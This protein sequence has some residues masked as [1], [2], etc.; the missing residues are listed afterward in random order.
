MVMVVAAVSALSSVAVTVVEPPFSAIVVLVSWSVATAAS[1][2]SSSI[3]SST[4]PVPS[5][6]RGQLALP[7]VM[8]P[9]MSTIRFGEATSL[10]LAVTVT[11]PVLIVVFF[12]MVRVVPVWVKSAA[13]ALVE[14]VAAM[15]SSTS[16]LDLPLKDAVTV[17]EPPFSAMVLSLSAK[18]TVGTGSSSSMFSV[19]SA[20]LATPLP[21][22]AVAEM[23]TLLVGES[24]SLFT[25]VIVTVPVL[26]VP[27]AAMVRV[28]L[29]L[30]VKSVAAAWSP[31]VAST[32][33]VTSWLDLP[34]K[35][36]VIVVEPPFSAMIASLSVMIKTTD[37]I[38][39]SSLMVTV[40]AVGAMMP[41]WPA[42]IVP[43]I[44]SCLFGA[45]ISL[46]TAVSV[47]T[48]VLD[49]VPEAMVSVV[50]LLQL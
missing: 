12:A 22:V 16:S 50:L 30:S 20:G 26:V 32:V 37:G 49:L 21:P 11:V 10:S 43:V 39:S 8:V 36:A 15:V 40:L 27:S 29:L 17:V 41:V 6:S 33:T 45:S 28:L 13:T 25:A 14:A 24:T 42:V 18:L 46:S 47:T 38:A 4:S 34:V 44:L 9:E 31:A 23:V 19:A 7:L 5:P 48:P 2:P 3:V 1:S 35:A